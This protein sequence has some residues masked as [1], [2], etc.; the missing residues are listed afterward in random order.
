MGNWSCH[1]V[2]GE[3]IRPPASLVGG[4]PHATSWSDVT[5]EMFGGQHRRDVM[6]CD[7]NERIER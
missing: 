3:L 7:V 4:S 2:T 5:G 1:S 6:R